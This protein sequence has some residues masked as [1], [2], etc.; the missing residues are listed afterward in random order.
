MPS[1]VDQLADANGLDLIRYSRMYEFPD[2]VKS[3][4][5]GLTNAPE[6]LRAGSLADPVRN[7]FPCHTK[8][9]CWLSALYFNEKAAEFHAKDRE[10]IRRR[11]EN[12]VDFWG[13][14]P[15]Y[16][17]LNVRCGELHKSA[18]EKLPDSSYAWIGESGPDG[19]RERRLPVRSSVEVKA[20]GDWLAEHGHRM[21]YR[22]RHAIA[23]RIME[24]AEGLGASL[25]NSR[26]Y[27]EKQGGYAD[28]DRSGI[29]ELMRTRVKLARS[30]EHRAQLEKVAHEVGGLSDGALTRSLLAEFVHTISQSD[31]ASG[32]SYGDVLRPPEDYV[33]GSTRS[34]RAEDDGAK[35]KTTSGSVWKT[36]DFTK[37]S[38]DDLSAIFGSDFVDEIRTAF[39]EI[40]PVKMAEVVRTFP[41][42][43]AES[44]D[45]LMATVGVAPSQ[46]R[47]A[48]GPTAEE[49]AKLLPR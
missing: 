41:K 31:R 28:F 4:D 16:E 26:D 2:F 25:G 8:A 6:A 29:V 37:L 46:K 14:R 49:Y 33:F 32:L 48:I 10:P 36:E 38:Q 45:R 44:L 7:Q 13:I 15:E 12:F 23:V 35:C 20:A 9:A 1:K 18:E 5:Y 42:P 40:D 11:L 47:A 39:G 43:E 27:I 24:R 19:S 17:R 3:A 30:S 34:K 21:E 22:D